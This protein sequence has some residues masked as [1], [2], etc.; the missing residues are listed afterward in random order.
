MSTWRVCVCGGGRAAGLV[1][2]ARRAVFGLK[3][4][5]RR[6]GVHLMREGSPVVPQVVP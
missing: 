2:E 4:G 5:K 3:G 6:E 1:L